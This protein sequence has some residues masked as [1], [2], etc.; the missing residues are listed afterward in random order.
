MR[1]KTF[2]YRQYPM[3]TGKGSHNVTRQPAGHCSQRK[4]KGNENQHKVSVR[5]QRLHEHI[6]TQHEELLSCAD[7]SWQSLIKP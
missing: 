1:H 5:V 3:P 2:N 7:L 4:Q 6:R